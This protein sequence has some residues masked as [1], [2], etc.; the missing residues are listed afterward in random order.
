[1]AALGYLGHL[2]YFLHVMADRE[3][4]RGRWKFKKSSN[5]RTTKAFQVK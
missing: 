4:T 5:S 3:K 2:G 1:M